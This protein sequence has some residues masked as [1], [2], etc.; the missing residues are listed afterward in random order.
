MADLV[1][2][3]ELE[4]GEM[5]PSVVDLVGA[6]L[7]GASSGF[8]GQWLMLRVDGSPLDDSTSLHDNGVSDGDVLLLTA[9]DSTC[10]PVFADATHYVVDA[11]GSAGSDSGW[12][13]RIGAITG[14]WCAGVGAT[15]LAWPGHPAPAN[16]AIAAAIVALVSTVAAMVMSRVDGD[17]LPTSA[18]G[19]TAAGFGAVAG[20]LMVPGGPAPPNFFLAAAICA[21]LSAVLHH[22]TSGGTTLFAGV[23]ALS[24]TAALAA[25]AATIW[26]APTATV[27]A[28]MAAA[29]VA[30]LGAAAKLSILLT[31]LSPRMPIDPGETGEDDANPVAA[32]TLRAERGHQVL[33]GLLAGFSLAAALGV[34]LVAADHD[35]RR[36]WA[37]IA[38]TAAVSVVLISRACRQQAVFRCAPLLVAGTFCATAV[39]VLAG[40][41]APQHAAWVGLTA[42]ALGAGVLWLPRVDLG[43]RLSPFARR[44]L[45]VVDYVALAAVVPLACWVGDLFGLVRGLSLT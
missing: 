31:G 22:A 2:P 45:E 4:I 1:L 11:F 17:P 40:S 27:A 9:E 37:G 26:P 13:R 5:L 30:M 32:E 3:A 19:L 24:T 34:V 39:F 38:F 6:Q 36:G 23:T 10:E 44:G 33:T 29:S 8:A 42:A 18:L 35:S 15:A 7:V 12:P 14:L 43:S 41:A 25:A 21:S 16:R 20:Y 28:V